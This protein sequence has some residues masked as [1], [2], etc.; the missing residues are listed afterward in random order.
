[1]LIIFAALLTVAAA[2]SAFAQPSAFESASVK[3]SEP[4]PPNVRFK[5]G[6]ESLQAENLTLEEFVER[7]FGLLEYQVSV[8]DW[9][10]EPR[11][12]ITA[13]TSGPVSRNQLMA[14][15]Q[16]LL[17]DRFHLAFHWADKTMPVY[18]LGPEGDHHGLTVSKV[19]DDDPTVGFG[20]GSQEPLKR[21]LKYT[22]I[23]MQ[24]LAGS[25]TGGLVHADLPVIDR[26]GLG[27]YY[28]FT[29]KFN[30]TGPPPSQ[31]EDGDVPVAVSN[32]LGIS[33]K[34]TNAPV[35]QLVVDHADQ[36][37]TGN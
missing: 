23:T 30:L 21:V 16:T 36:E 24:T 8:P 4:N 13:R 37:P 32:Q 28:D 35:R 9:M 22:H 2:P 15:L 7:A 3:K 19:P 33:I 29:L 31:I 18:V 25:L 1:M 11:F 10:N 17:E 6:P 5:V 14:M 27:G 12:V 26:T 34:R 20:P